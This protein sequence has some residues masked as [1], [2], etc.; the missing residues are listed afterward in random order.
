MKPFAPLTHQ[1]LLVTNV[2]LVR[3]AWAGFAHL[4]F[5]GLLGL[6]WSTGRWSPE[7]MVTFSVYQGLF[8]KLRLQRAAILGDEVDDCTYT[9]LHTSTRAQAQTH[10]CTYTH[11][12]I[13]TRKPITDAHVH[14]LSQKLTHHLQQQRVRVLIC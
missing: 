4:G 9:H 3:S 1:P 11:V 2:G 7:L 12:H 5:V 6:V 8:G 14:T 13:Y 10:T